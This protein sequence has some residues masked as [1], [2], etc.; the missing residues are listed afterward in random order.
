MTLAALDIRGKQ[1]KRAM[2][3]YLAANVDAFLEELAQEFERLAA[4]NIALA[5]R[6]QAMEEQLAHY[7]TLDQT[8]R[9]TLIVAEQSAEEL[10]E[11]ARKEAELGRSEAALAA[12]QAVAEAYPAQQ[13]LAKEIAALRDLAAEL[14][15]RFR[16][17]LEHYGE[18]LEAA[19]Q[20][21]EAAGTSAAGH[22]AQ[23]G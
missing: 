18:Q 20:G 19:E 7:R 16:S 21:A 22:G 8:L 6:C 14:R 17:L 11:T 23:R 3:G 12:R 5:E 15:F 10:Q 1:F 2:R 13:A 4:E 9:K